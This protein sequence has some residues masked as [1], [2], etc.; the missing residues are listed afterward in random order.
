MRSSIPVA[1]TRM[2]S[3]MRTWRKEREGGGE[4][5]EGGWEGEAEE[6]GREEEEELHLPVNVSKSG[7]KKKKKHSQLSLSCVQGQGCWIT[8]SKIC[9]T[10]W[11]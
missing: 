7:Y 5:G 8:G 2:S 4:K 9:V 11:Q 6:G 3:S 1:V 10:Q